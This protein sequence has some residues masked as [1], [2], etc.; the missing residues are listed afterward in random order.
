MNEQIP[1]ILDELDPIKARITFES[2]I[3]STKNLLSEKESNALALRYGLLG[4]EKHEICDIAIRFR[5]SIPS[6]QKLLKDALDKS[7]N[8]PIQNLLHEASSRAARF[9]RHQGKDGYADL[10]LVCKLLIKADELN[11][12]RIVFET[13]GR[14][15]KNC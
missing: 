4:K 13:S 5:T 9:C 11:D 10:E 3:S 8:I 14:K 6:I 7:L 1:E 2:A 12:C 15:C